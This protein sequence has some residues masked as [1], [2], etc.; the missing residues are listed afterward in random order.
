MK[1]GLGPVPG[2]DPATTGARAHQYEQ[3]QEQ[4]LIGRH[5]HSGGG[6]REEE[7]SADD[8]GHP[9]GIDECEEKHGATDPSQLIFDGYTKELG[10][11]FRQDIERVGRQ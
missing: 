3:L 6:G 10:S 1:P 11:R 9:F 5:R 4:D 2:P 8:A 7:N